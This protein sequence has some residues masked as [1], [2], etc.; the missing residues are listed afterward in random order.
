MNNNTRPLAARAALLWNIA[1]PA[2]PSWAMVGARP[3]AC[4]ARAASRSHRTSRR[5]I[6]PSSPRRAGHG[7]TTRRRRISRS[8]PRN[9]TRSRRNWTSTSR[10]PTPCTRWNPAS[11]APRLP[12]QS[13]D[14]PL[15][16]RPAVHRR[17]ARRA[18]RQE[19]L[20]RQSTTAASTSIIP[21]MSGLKAPEL[22]LNLRMLVT[23]QIVATMSGGDLPPGL[24]HG[25][26]LYSEGLPG[27]TARARR[28]AQPAGGRGSICP[29]GRHWP[30]RPTTPRRAAIQCRRLPDRHLRPPPISR[31]P[32]G[33]E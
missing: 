25:T 3:R 33:A 22:T 10:S 6:R 24:V 4:P 26:A 14:L 18:G 28:H 32:H 30:I 20:Q 23:Q 31:L 2:A 1:S 27:G 13:A 12:L 5:T 15:H 21:R 11:S 7:N 17:R 19:S 9:T 8:T 16:R 29:I